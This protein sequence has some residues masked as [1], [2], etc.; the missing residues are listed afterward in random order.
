MT[1]VQTCALPIFATYWVVDPE[2]ELIEVWT[3]D[4]EVPVIE[5][6]RVVWHRAGARQP[7][8]IDV[9]ALFKPI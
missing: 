5:R 6:E 1:G 2:R 9:K 8:K 4:A 3:P 7:L